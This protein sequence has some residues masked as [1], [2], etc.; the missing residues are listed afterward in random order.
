M[1]RLHRGEATS[2]AELRHRPES[3]IAVLLLGLLT[4]LL[5][6]PSLIAVGMVGWPL[7]LAFGLALLAVARFVRT[8]RELRVI[9]WIVAAYGVMAIAGAMG[10]LIA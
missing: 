7:S 8:G 5:L 3:S 6:T 1:T 4:L 2:T 10:M 9:R